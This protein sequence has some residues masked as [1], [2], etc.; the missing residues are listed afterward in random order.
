MRAKFINETQNFERTGNPKKSMGIGGI[1][2]EKEKNKKQEAM[3][4]AQKDTENIANQEW[5]K[6]L[7]KSLVGKKITANM[8][9]LPTMN[10]KTHIMTGKRIT[11]DFTI[12][13]Q[14]I[15]TQPLTDLLINI[16]IADTDNKIYVI[17]LDEKIYFE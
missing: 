6:Y 8:T 16:L 17:S 15:S 10:I 13:V 12:T 4:Q 7:Q 9:S 14:D 5:N 3:R 2:L 1:I 11:K